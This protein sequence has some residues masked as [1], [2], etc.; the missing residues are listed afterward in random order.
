MFPYPLTKRG[1]LGV[2]IATPEQT[3]SGGRLGDDVEVL[4]EGVKGI[5]ESFRSEGGGGEVEA[6]DN[7]GGLRG[8]GRKNMMFCQNRP[9]Q[10]AAKTG[11]NEKTRGGPFG[12]FTCD[13]PKL[14]FLENTR[15]WLTSPSWI[16]MKSHG[17]VE[18]RFSRKGFTSAFRREQAFQ[19]HSATLRP[20]QQVGM[21]LP[22]PWRFEYTGGLRW[23]GGGT[24]M[25]TDQGL[26]I[27]LEADA[28]LLRLKLCDFGGD[29]FWRY[30][31]DVLLQF[32]YAWVV[33]VVPRGRVA[34]G[35]L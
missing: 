29:F 24:A 10:K 25:P 13:Q 17:A 23:G 30:V 14:L 20:V 15:G 7:K 8:K 9:F 34:T 18:E 32:L 3:A 12:G 16:Q 27:G 19:V 6:E 4:G 22:R 33:V 11:G 2:Q 31:G 5:G 1:K 26:I 28:L 21:R 35:L